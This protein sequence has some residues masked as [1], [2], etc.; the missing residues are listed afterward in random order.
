MKV[1]LGILYTKHVIKRNQLGREEIFIG[2]A[3][4]VGMLTALYGTRLFTVGNILF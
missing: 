2:V 3:I 1:G 4:W